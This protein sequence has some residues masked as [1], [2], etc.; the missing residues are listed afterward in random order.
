MKT[1][2]EGVTVGVS[3]HPG[4]MPGDRQN[5]FSPS[6]G[7]SY[8]DRSPSGP[9]ASYFQSCPLSVQCN[10]NDFSQSYISA[11]HLLYIKL[12]SGFL[13]PWGQ[14]SDLLT[15][16][17]FLHNLGPAGLAD[18]LPRPPLCSVRRAHWTGALSS[19]NVL[20]SLSLTSWLSFT[21]A[22]FAC[23]YAHLSSRSWVTH[24]FLWKA[25]LTSNLGSGSPV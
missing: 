6:T 2:R 15:V 9:P 3:W 12:F 17:T 1:K 21:S 11:C 22:F 13:L 5:D 25:P 18:L 19:F 20:G 8:Q 23:Y 14:S 7:I 24:H 10:Q 16:F 4:G